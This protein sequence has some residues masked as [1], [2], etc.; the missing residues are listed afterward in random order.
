MQHQQNFQNYTITGFVMSAKMNTYEG[1][2]KLTPFVE[3]YL[4][5]Y[6]LTIGAIVIKI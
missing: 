6:S 5:K 2:T 1:L 3:N 4:N